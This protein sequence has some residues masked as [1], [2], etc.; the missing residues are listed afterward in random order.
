[1][2]L[3]S[4]ADMYCDVVM[5]V[6]PHKKCFI[7]MVQLQTVWIIYMMIQNRRRMYQMK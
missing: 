5:D 7:G 2:D 4:S 1:M 6:S 3:S